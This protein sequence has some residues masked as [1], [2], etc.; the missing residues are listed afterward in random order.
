MASS[1]HRGCASPAVASLIR[2]KLGGQCHCR[3]VPDV[4]HGFHSSLRSALNT[5]YG[6]SPMNPLVNRTSGARLTCSVS[7]ATNIPPTKTL[8][9]DGPAPA[10]ATSPWRSRQV[11]HGRGGRSAPEYPVAR[12]LDGRSSEAPATSTGLPPSGTSRGRPQAPCRNRTD[13]PS[14]RELP[15]APRVPTA[16]EWLRLCEPC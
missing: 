14:G 4:L 3:P 13:S 7:E 10:S 8:R 16:K 2:R 11:P 5:R 1:R 15:K 9:S 6:S 12:F